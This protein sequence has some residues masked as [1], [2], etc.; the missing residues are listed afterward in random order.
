[1]GKT[2]GR[3]LYT[4]SDPDNPYPGKVLRLG[5]EPRVTKAELLRSLGLNLD[6]SPIESAA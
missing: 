1:M 6:G 5:R 2:E 3:E 4:K